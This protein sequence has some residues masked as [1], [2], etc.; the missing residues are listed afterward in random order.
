MDVFLGSI[1]KSN[2]F[3]IK[4]IFLLKNLINKNKN[5]I[6][7][8]YWMNILCLFFFKMNKFII[9]NIVKKGEYCYSYLKKLL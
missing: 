6:I 2:E 8:V 4:Y 9:K 3:V 7:V 5:F 1:Y